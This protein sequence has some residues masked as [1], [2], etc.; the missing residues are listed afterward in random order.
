MPMKTINLTDIK[1]VVFVNK[2]TGATKDVEVLKLGN[3]EIWQKHKITV[4]FNGTATGY[5][6]ITDAMTYVDTLSTTYDNPATIKLYGNIESTSSITISSGYRRLDLNNYNLRLDGGISQSGGT[7]YICDNSQKQEGV[8]DINYMTATG[9]SSTFIIE[10]GTINNRAD[11]EIQDGKFEMLDGYVTMPST[12]STINNGIYVYSKNSTARLHI[13]GGTITSGYY[14]VHVSTTSA[15]IENANIINCGFDAIR[16]VGGSK[17]TIKN[18]NISNN[19]GCAITG[20]SGDAATI[21]VSDTIMKNNASTKTENC[22]I[23]S[24][25]DTVNMTRCTLEDNATRVFYIRNKA[26]VT[27]TDCTIKNNTGVGAHVSEGNLTLTNCECTN[28]EGGG[29]YTSSSAANVTLD[30]N[31][32]VINNYKNNVLNNIYVN[33]GTSVSVSILKT[34]TGAVGFTL[35]EGTGRVAAFPETSYPIPTATYLS[36]DPQYSIETRSGY[37]YLYLV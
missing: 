8:L 3:I 33:S 9:S 4:T 27:L 10:S 7:F 1:S 13:S 35:Y 37:H 26:K 20:T 22:V 30:G 18:C 28:N 15:I 29:I 21:T 12:Y 5:D 34:F 6:T 25:G 14:A 19:N 17:A 2:S 31:T 24:Y 23:W 16:V 11:F 36:D 32:N